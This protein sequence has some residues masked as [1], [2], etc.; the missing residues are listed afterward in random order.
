YLA[1]N[2][3]DD[4]LSAAR[5][6][7]DRESGDYETWVLL[8]RQY[9]RLGRT[10]LAAGAYDRALACRSLDDRP[11]LRSQ[12]AFSLGRLREELGQCDQAVAAYLQVVKILDQPYQLLESSFLT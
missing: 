8:G 4:A 5:K 6:A 1:L 7:V 9:K 11:D 10:D 2:R 12:F 3:S